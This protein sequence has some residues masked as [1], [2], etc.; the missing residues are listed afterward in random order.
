MASIDIKRSHN[1]GKETA[2]QKAEELANDMQGKMGIDWR[3]EG[4]DI[5]F[6]ADSGAAKGVKGTVSVSDDEV[7]VAIDLPLLLKAM[8]GTISG[9][10]EDKLGKL[11]GGG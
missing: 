9:R 3:W 10:V 6:K 2:K 11:I 7:R 8:K 1:L 5:R 4:D